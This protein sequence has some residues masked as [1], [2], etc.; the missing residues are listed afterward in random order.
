M[1]DN[2]DNLNKLNSNRLKSNSDESKKDKLYSEAIDAIP[3]FVFDKKVEAVFDDMIQRSVPGY[4]L[5]ISMVALLA[6][7]YCQA[8]TLVYD[9]GCSTGA[10]I[11]A[12]AS[13]LESNLTCE[14]VAIDNAQA[15][16]EQA[17]KNYDNAA[18]A[19]NIIWQC[20][21]VCNSSVNNASLVIMNYTLQFVPQSQRDDLIGGIAQGLI[22]GG[23]MLLSEKI[24]YQSADLDI[25]MNELYHSFKSANGYSN[26]EIAQK[27][28]ALENVL[29]RETIDTHVSRLRSAGFTKVLP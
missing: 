3:E 11:I 10:N 8:N 2:K 27:R 22:A 29:V 20:E 1:S 25:E 14:I 9:L 23:A 13:A 28:T 4:R 17:R 19:T 7:R 6:Q 18:L 5:L 26:L 21:D 24:C 15:M 12:L 16:L